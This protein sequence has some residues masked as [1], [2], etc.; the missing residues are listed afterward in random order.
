MR[1]EE[2][3]EELQSR[4]QAFVES[5]QGDCP[6]GPEDTLFIAQYTADQ[7]WYRALDLANDQV[8][9]LIIFNS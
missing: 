7:T 8:R 3:L 4:I 5:P 2:P 6:P 9:H 1:D